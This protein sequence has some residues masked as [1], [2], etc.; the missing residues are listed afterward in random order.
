MH[1]VKNVLVFLHM[2]SAT[3]NTNERVCMGI[4]T[5]LARCISSVSTVALKHV[6]HRPAANFPGK[7]AL[8]V[9]PHIIADMTKKLACGSICVVGTNGKTT[10]TNLIADTLEAAGKSVVCNRTGANLDSG[11]ATSLLHAKKSDWGVFECDE[12][13]LTKILPFTQSTYVLLLN[14]F[15]DQLD[16]VGE[17]DHTQDAIVQALK[18]SPNSILIY[19]GDDPLCEAIARKAPNPHV[20]FGIDEDLHLSNHT[21]SDA[22]MCQICEGIL[23]YDYRQ[24]GQL[25][26]YHCPNGDFDRPYLS[27]AARHCHIGSDEITFDVTSNVKVAGGDAGEA[28]AATAALGKPHTA[29]IDA[30]VAGAYMLY[31]LLAVY[32]AS[33]LMGAPD[34]AVQKAISAFHPDNGRL[35]TL[36]VGNHKVLL[37]LAKNPTGFNQNL[38]LIHQEKGRKAAAFF[39][40]DKQADGHDISWIWDVNFDA[41]AD[42][43]IRVCAGGIRKNDVQVRLKYGNVP[44]TLAEDARDAMQ[45]FLSDPEL[46]GCPIF[47][48]ANYTAL[49]KVRTQLVEMAEM[50]ELPQA[51]KA[52]QQEH[53]TKS[54]AAQ[55]DEARV[56]ADKTAAH[57]HVNGSAKATGADGEAHASH[58]LQQDPHA[59]GLTRPLQIYHLMPRLLNL[60]GDNGNVKVLQRRC[61]WRGIPVDVHNVRF[62]ETVDLDKADIVFLGGGPD[63]QQKLAS[64]MLLEIRD[65]IKDYVEDNGVL[66]AICGGYQILGPSW[67]AAGK[68]VKGLSILHMHTDPAPKGGARIIDNI[69]IK[70]PLSTDLVVGYENHGGRTYLRS[71][72]Q[73][74]G[75]VHNHIGHGNNDTSG[76]DGALYK[77]VVATYLHGPLLGKNPQVADWILTKAIERR[78]GHAVQLPPLD[79]TI[80]RNANQ[81]MCK[82]LGA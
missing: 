64:E 4:Q 47:M 27:F 54:R 51:N 70:S 60:Y 32:A 53:Q 69:V 55:A 59:F 1:G 81:F 78:T 72:L 2:W 77:H 63:R 71:D 31:N 50:A 24:Y 30:H 67:Y 10:I 19:N 68:K 26:A 18:Q 76:A 3:Q 45:K 6:F 41:L 57:I 62:G 20:A 79:D 35:Q 66:L 8:Y 22:P 61:Q 40:N 29:H 14:L 65:Q 82:R 48:I 13:W 11:V 12:L 43:D 33:S 80:E 46:D 5:G 75:R 52:V 17:I 44:S 49:P 42:E 36:T 56:N 25:G 9:D 39:I 74:F 21:V 37:N 16:R 58:N 34:S 28:S 23:Q 7:I 15:R 38:Q 73:P